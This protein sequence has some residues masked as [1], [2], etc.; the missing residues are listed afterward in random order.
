V[1]YF[2]APDFAIE[3]KLW[4]KFEVEK[5]RINSL[6]PKGEVDEYLLK[7]QK[8]IQNTLRELKKYINLVMNQ[9]KD[10]NWDTAR[11]VL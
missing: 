3:R 9:Y 4:K 8:L 11:F 2:V 1:K 5:I 6:M 7:K 10:I